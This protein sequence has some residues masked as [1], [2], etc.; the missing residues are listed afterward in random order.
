MATIPK[1]GSKWLGR[2]CSLIFRRRER[3][4]KVSVR[5]YQVSDAALR[6]KVCNGTNLIFLSSEGDY[7]SRQEQLNFLVLL[8]CINMLKK[9][10]YPD[11]GMVKSKCYNGFPN[12]DGRCMRKNSLVYVNLVRLTLSRLNRR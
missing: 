11:M 2:I 6:Y 8:A 4:L 1:I 9:F 10:H 7:G 12:A 5:P 3:A